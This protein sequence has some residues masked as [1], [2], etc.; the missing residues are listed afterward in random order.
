MPEYPEVTVVCQ[1]LSKLLLGKKINNCELLSEKFAKNSSVKDFEEFFNNKTF[2]KINNTGKFIEFIFDDKS[3]AIVHLR[4]EG[5]FFIRKTSDLEKYRFKHDH[6][7]FHL[8]NDETL[9]YNDSRGFGSFETISKENKLS[10]KEIKNLANLPKDV[11]ID[12]LY[13][14]LQNTTRSIKTILLDQKLVLGIGN[15]YADETLFASKIFPM[16]KAKNL[17]KAQL[18]TLMDNAQRIMDESIKLGG[19]TVHS[20]QS[21]NGIDGKFQQRLKVYGRAK[22]NCLECGSFVK[23]VKLDFK[24]NGRGTSY[25]PNC[26]NEK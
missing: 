4:M 14:K 1:S 8:G 15:I 23:K 5:K 11:D 25:C 17:S 6:I 13:K 24:Q 9:A 16:E 10:V 2:K 12:Y 26:Q 19:S 20:Y 18:K 7:Y 21:V 22:L 3:R